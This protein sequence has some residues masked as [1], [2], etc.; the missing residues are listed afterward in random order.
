MTPEQITLA[1]AES[2]AARVGKLLRDKFQGELEVTRKQEPGKYWADFVSEADLAAEA[3]IVAELQTYFPDDKIIAEE[4]SSEGNPQGERAWLV[5]PIDGTMNFIRGIPLWAVSIACKDTQGLLAACVY[6]PI[7]HELFSAL[8]GQGAFLNGK[9]LQAAHAEDL[10]AGLLVSHIGRDPRSGAPRKRGM[11]E[12]IQHFG[13]RSLG[14]AALALAWTASGR[15]DVT[16]YECPL[17]EWD[18]AAGIL[19]CREM[20][21]RADFL[22]PLES[23][24]HPRLIA[25]PTELCQQLKAQAQLLND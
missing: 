18:V 1:C 15:V 22:E 9:P 21:L 2:A 23:G 13:H 14:S 11:A 16:Y 8:R 19:I 20:G 3:E 6:D 24:L 7:R 10:T 12:A 17:W 4:G 25:G 5:D